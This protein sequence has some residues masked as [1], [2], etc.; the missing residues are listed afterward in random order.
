MFICIALMMK[1]VCDK[2][3]IKHAEPEKV[4]QKIWIRK[5]VNVLESNQAL[6]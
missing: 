6:T 2:V 4:E 5:Y 3:Y 1:L